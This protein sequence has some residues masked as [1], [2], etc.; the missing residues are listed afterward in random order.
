[1]LPPREV[2]PQFM[3]AF[4]MS[5]R[6]DI[7]HKYVD[8]TK[9]KATVFT[10]NQINEFLQ[11]IAKRK[12]F[13]YGPTDRW[14][15]MALDNFSISGKS[16]AIM[17]SETP[18]YESIALS[19]G[20][21]C[22]TIEYNPIVSEHPDITPITPS[23]FDEHP[24]QFD[25]AFSISSFEHDGL[26]RYGDPIDPDADLKAMEKMR[27]IVRQGGLLFLAVPVGRDAVVWNSNRIYGEARLPKLLKGWN[28]IASFGFSKSMMR[29]NRSARYQPVFVLRNGEAKVD[30]FPRATLHSSFTNTLRDWSTISF[31][32]VLRRL[33]FGQRS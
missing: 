22:T 32:F 31:G 12:T 7:R 11:E 15:Y 1:M 10:T 26:G 9:A 14:L 4:S 25:A 16:V 2:P 17:G 28:L 21:K 3:E 13:Y 8:D 33:G 24:R 23:Q 18:L 6:A 20:A 30:D 27:G 5:G 19:R 29:L